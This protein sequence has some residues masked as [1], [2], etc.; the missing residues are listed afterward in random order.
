MT[1]AV[2]ACNCTIAGGANALIFFL[3][4]GHRFFWYLLVYPAKPA[5]GAGR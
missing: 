5:G 1:R 2:F 3:S 4:Y